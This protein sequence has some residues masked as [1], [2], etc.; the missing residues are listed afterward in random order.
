MA[1]EV[2][3]TFGGT[4]QAGDGV[5]IP[6]QADDELLRLCKD[7]AFA[8]VLT[9]RQMGK[10]SL[11]VRTAEAL[12][13]QGI[14]AADVDLSG[15]G[16]VVTQDTWYVTLL[17][18]IMESLVVETDVEGWWQARSHLSLNRRLALFLQEV[19]L[20]EIAERVVIFIDE[21]DTT[22][23]L[24]FTDDFFVVIRSIHNARARV[25]A[26]K[27]ISFVLVG[28]ATP[29][30]L[31]SDPRRTPFNIGHRVEL[32][33]FTFEEAQPLAQ[34][35]GMPLNEAKQ[36]L[37]WGLQWT[38]GHPFL[39]QRLCWEIART[40]RPSWTEADVDKV[41]RAT[42]FGLMS[43][44]DRNLQFVRDSLTLRPSDPA[45]VFRVY[46]DILSDEDIRDDA[47]SIVKS[48]FNLSGVVRSVRGGL[49]VLNR[50]YAT[51]FDLDWVEEHWPENVFKR[52]A[53][54]IAVA[55]VILF[56]VG[57]AVTAFVQYG[58]ANTEAALRRQAVAARDSTEAALGTTELARDSTADALVRADSLLLVAEAARDS[59][60]GALEIAQTAR[61]IAELARNSTADA[62]GI[63]ELARDSTVDALVRADLLLLVA[64]AARDST[65]RAL[66]SATEAR[67]QTLGLALA[68]SALDELERGNAEL[69]A[70]LAREAFLFNQESGDEFSNEVYDA[71]R[72]SLKALVP[73]ARDISVFKQ[74]DWV[75]AITYG[76]ED[77]WTVLPH[78]DGY[79]FGDTVETFSPDGRLRASGDVE[80]IVWLYG[81]AT[82]TTTELRGHQGPVTALAFSP[83]GTLLASG[84]GDLTIRL[85][86]VDSPSSKPIVLQDHTDWVLALAFGPK[87]ETLASGS[88]D[89]TVRLWQINPARLAEEVCTVVKRPPLTRQEWL[90]FVGTD[91]PYSEYVPCSTPT[92]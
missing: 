53:S 39:T 55:A 6:R 30:E 11:I 31:I 58:A 92:Q 19:L 51:V 26:F 1:K 80:G 47:Q 44:E 43:S 64:E 13:E 90:D 8:Y 15:F 45:K 76:P 34:G 33:D 21:I 49:R 86:Q 79:A 4:V 84:S 35:L 23:S 42:F 66:M 38:G 48:Q 50:I 75:R 2:I 22:L 87:G 91:I 59:T 17:D 74:D 85:W 77:Q 10:S 54:H 65:A 40:T 68:N 37:R 61:E 36:V 18:A 25:P 46:R 70:L 72:Q 81:T 12:E 83:N 5:Y 14:R 28:A 67:L 63:T 60:R 88:A 78:N 52:Y 7:G 16:T 57:L 27:R 82:G 29:G 20:A 9:P 73:E 69:G 41:V 32:T 24:D 89:R 3:Y 71:L 56:F 62:L